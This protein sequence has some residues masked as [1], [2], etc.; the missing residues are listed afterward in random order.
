MI[1]FIV[2]III[3]MQ[4]VSFDHVELNF[5][6]NGKSIDAPIMGIK[7][8]TYPALYGMNL[9]FF[10]IFHLAEKLNM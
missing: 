8:T 3:M 1:N 2:T 10:S 9:Y 5:Y 6:V 4:G 7:S